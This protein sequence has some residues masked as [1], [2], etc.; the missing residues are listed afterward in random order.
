MSIES[1][2][3]GVLC[4]G[5]YGLALQLP[6]ASSEPLDKMIAELVVATAAVAQMAA[7]N[8]CSPRAVPHVQAGLLVGLQV[9]AGITEIIQEAQDEAASRRMLTGI[10]DAMDRPR[11]QGE[12]RSGRT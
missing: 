12:F 8:D 4:I 11:A 10:A 2:Y 5:T 3:I 7:A 9:L 6:D 1:E